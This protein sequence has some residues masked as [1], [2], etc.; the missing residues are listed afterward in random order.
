MAR[1]KGKN[2]IIDKKKDQWIVV[3]GEGREK[4]T[5]AKRLGIM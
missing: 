1:R 4:S 3:C 5:I 2:P